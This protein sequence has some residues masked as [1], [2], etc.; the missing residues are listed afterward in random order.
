VSSGHEPIRSYQRIFRPERRIYHLEGR[1]LPVPGG[2]PLRWLAYATAVLL[3]VLALG[4]GSSLVLALIGTGAAI[5]GLFAGGRV[6][7]AIAGAAG[8]GGVWLAGV[9]LGF[10]DWPLRLIVVPV[11]VATLATQAT[12]DGRH[13]DRFAVSWLALWLAPCRR[14]LGRA[15]PTPGV[16]Q[17]RDAALWVAPDERAPGLR[18]A[19]V[20]G[21][22]TVCFAGGVRV[23]RAGLRQR[24]L[25]VRP[26]SA[27]SRRDE[28]TTSRLAL[29]EDEVLEVRP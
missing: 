24:R 7:A 3:A 18:R 17:V 6:G 19:R 27:G 26:A 5:A 11:A 14:S 10:L 25:V 22:G 2:V 15:M 21:K 28:L 20:R 23:R 13:A 29:S 1:A 16:A 12:P 4:S 8:L 9:A